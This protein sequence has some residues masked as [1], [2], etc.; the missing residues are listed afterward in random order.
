MLDLVSV[1]VSRYHER[2]QLIS[3]AQMKIV[4]Y[5]GFSNESDTL[6]LRLERD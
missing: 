4:E 2:V 5:S 6:F 3:F 1:T